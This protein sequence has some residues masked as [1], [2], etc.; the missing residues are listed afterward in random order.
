MTLIEDLKVLLMG[1]Y[2][3]LQDT[4]NWLR[5]MPGSKERSEALSTLQMAFYAQ[6][7]MEERI[8]KEEEAVRLAWES[9]H[10]EREDEIRDEMALSYDEASHGK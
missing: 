9:F 6:R 8:T 1:Q 4:F 5:A 2:R 10:N 3:D 7:H